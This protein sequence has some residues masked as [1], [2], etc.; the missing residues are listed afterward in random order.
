MKVV[1][2]N[3]NWVP[4]T[5]LENIPRPCIGD[6]DIVTEQ[7]EEV[8]TDYIYYRLKRFGRPWYLSSHFITLPESDADEVKEKDQQAIVNPQ[9]A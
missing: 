9:P 6:N 1:C 3:D 2:I 7:V 8:G 4:D 5:G